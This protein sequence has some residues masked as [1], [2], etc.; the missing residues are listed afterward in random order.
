MFY[1]FLYCCVHAPHMPNFGDTGHGDSKHFTPTP[2]TKLDFLSKKVSG[3]ATFRSHF[4]VYTFS[5]K[6]SIAL[7][8]VTEG[9]A[10][11]GAEDLVEL[12]QCET[13]EIGNGTDGCSRPP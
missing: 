11:A 9:A 6:L 7:A 1:S 12:M 3:G 5:A 8:P 4:T 13:A 10:E 2:Q